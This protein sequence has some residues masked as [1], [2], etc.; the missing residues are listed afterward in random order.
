MFSKSI[1]EVMLESAGG[2]C[3]NNQIIPKTPGEG[4]NKLFTYVTTQNI[5]CK[6]K[7]KKKT[8]DLWSRIV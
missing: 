3:H 7:T 2:Q 4:V 5:N 6:K 1:K 8:G